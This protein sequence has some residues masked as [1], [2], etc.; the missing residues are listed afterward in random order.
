MYIYDVTGTDATFTSTKQYVVFTPNQVIDLE[1]PVFLNSIV[2]TDFNGQV[3]EQNI[4]WKFLQEYRDTNAMSEAKRRKPTFSDTLINRLQMI[5]TVPQGQFEIKIVCQRFQRHIDDS[6]ELNDPRGPKCNPTLLRKMV[7]DIEEIKHT[8]MLVQDITSVT[9]LTAD[10]LPVDIRGDLSTNHVIEEAHKVDVPNNRQ[11]LVPNYGAFYAHDVKLEYFVN[12]AVMTPKEDDPTVYEEREIVNHTVTLVEGEDYYILGLDPDKTERTYSTSG[13][14]SF[15]FLIRPIVG[16]VKLSYH[17]F[18]GTINPVDFGE[19]KK[20]L[21]NLHKVIVNE[22]VITKQNLSRT[23][24]I[25]EISRRLNALERHMLHFPMERFCVELNASE[26]HWFNFAFLD[27]IIWKTD[28]PLYSQVGEFLIESLEGKFKYLVTANVNTEV[29]NKA[30]DALT[31][32]V[33]AEERQDPLQEIRLR[34]VWM[35][36]GEGAEDA[37][38]PKYGIALQLGMRLSVNDPDIEKYEILVSNRSGMLS[39]WALDLSSHDLKRPSDTEAVLPGDNGSHKWVLAQSNN[40]NVAPQATKHFHSQKF[41]TTAYPCLIRSTTTETPSGVPLSNY[42]WSRDITDDMQVITPEPAFTM[43]LWK[44]WSPTE[45]ESIEFQIM[46]LL[47]CTIL[48][49]RSPVTGNNGS[50]LFFPRDLCVLNWRLRG[51]GQ[52]YSL[53]INVD[54]GTKSY[55][56]KRFQLV[57]VLLFPRHGTAKYLDQVPVSYRDALMASEG[58]QNAM[59]YPNALNRANTVTIFAHL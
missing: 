46:D 17:A 55:T 16:T 19:M 52:N 18:G 24:E 9:T 53:D 36:P 59:T 51:S 47:E 22:K 35:E 27:N 23:V 21:L 7:M 8:Q 6:Y 26:I 39:K 15:I 13:V 20:L 48:S 45:I 3:L 40:T 4:A 56:M 10:M 11:L 43:E 25:M 44:D 42:Q 28:D 54:L 2:I 31:I 30:L 12:E 37:G 1:E 32:A 38:L 49:S 33:L 57:K 41:L 50:V 5:T 34:A 58:Y 29:V 14:Y